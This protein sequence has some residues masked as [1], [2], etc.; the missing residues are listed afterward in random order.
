[1]TLISKRFWD[2]VD[3]RYIVRRML[4]GVTTWL[5]VDSYFWAAKFAETTGKTG[6]EAGL[7]VA[8]VTTPVSLLL[9]LIAK[10]YADGRAS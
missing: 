10:I 3:E 1:M 7:I 5:A 4:L 9:G 2:W 8:A 6:A